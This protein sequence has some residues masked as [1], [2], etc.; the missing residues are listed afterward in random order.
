MDSN[1]LRAYLL[2]ASPCLKAFWFAGGPD[3]TG[4]LPWA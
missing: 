3:L 2:A 1:L 4:I